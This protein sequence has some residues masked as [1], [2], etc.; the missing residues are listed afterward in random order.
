MAQ[1]FQPS[2]SSN[3]RLLKP[4]YPNIYKHIPQMGIRNNAYKT[5][6]ALHTRHKKLGSSKPNKYATVSF[7]PCGL[8]FMRQSCRYFHTCQLSWWVLLNSCSAF[9]IVVGMGWKDSSD[10]H[11]MEWALPIKLVHKFKRQVQQRA[12]YFINIRKSIS[13]RFRNKMKKLSILINTIIP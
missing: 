3:I 6:V 9:L 10:S 4:M 7:F 12:F 5:E 2:N 11:L 13:F 1:I 8:Y